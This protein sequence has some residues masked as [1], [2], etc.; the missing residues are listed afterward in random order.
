M[1]AKDRTLLAGL[2]FA[3]SDKKNPLHDLACQYLATPERATK[4]LGLVTAG[5]GDRRGWVVDG[6]S[7]EEHITKGERQYRSTIGFADLIIRGRYLRSGDID[8]E[9][10][11]RAEKDAKSE[12]YEIEN[13]I[14]SAYYEALTE[15]RRTKGPDAWTV[16]EEELPRRRRTE[17]LEAA[18]ET[19]RLKH[20]Q[21]YES[22]FELRYDS[23]RYGGEWQETT[24]GLSF[25][26]R[27]CEIL[28]EVK[29]GRVPTGDSLRQFA[30]YDEYLAVGHK[31]LVT[32]YDL[33]IADVDALRSKEVRHL[34]LGPDFDRYCASRNEEDVA[35][36]LEI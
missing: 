31:I 30:L 16:S 36:S 24:Y 3:D 2:G 10:R 19:I 26:G 35:P 23:Q 28:V 18:T 1:H 32:A 22:P 6:A 34:R 11:A 29:I 15:I 14:N 7:L 12:R 9:R 25:S 20:Q 21:V 5:V 8:A 27:R 17:A 4:I 33:G 13:K